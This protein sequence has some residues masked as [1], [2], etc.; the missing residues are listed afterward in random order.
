[1]ALLVDG[2]GIANIM[3]ISVLERRQEIGLRRA[4]GATGVTSAGSSWSSQ[5]ALAGL[6]PAR[7]A[8]RLPPTEAPAS[9]LPPGCY[10]RA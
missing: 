6:Y 3:V 8:A 9:A 2:V 4:L 1:M 10:W 7:R 5:C